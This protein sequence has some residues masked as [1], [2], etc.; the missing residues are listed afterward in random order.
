MG[1]KIELTDKKPGKDG[2]SLDRLLA[3]EF[4]LS[5]RTREAHRNV[6]GRNL[7][8]LRKL[9]KVQYESM[10]TIVADLGTKI[11]TSGVLPPSILADFLPITRLS[12][13]NE[14][15]TKQNQIIEALLDDH[16]SIIDALRNDGPAAAGE[17]TDTG[18]AGFVTGLLGR[19]E[20]MAL[21]LKDWLR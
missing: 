6:H 1:A 19:H 16:E 5:M 18:T 21:A 3:D 15:F 9:F 12:R 7:I 13:H 11:R 14:R 10:D 8:E 20:K 4:V 2:A 17:H